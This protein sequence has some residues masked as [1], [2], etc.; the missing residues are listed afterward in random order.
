MENILIIFNDRLINTREVE[1]RVLYTQ[2]HLKRLE[3]AGLFPRRCKLGPSRVAW[4]LRA[5]IEWMQASIDQ[6]RVYFPHIDEVEIDEAD[7]F[8]GKTRASTIARISVTQIRKLEGRGEFPTRIQLG[9]R[10]VAWLER[11]VLA[12]RDAR[13]ANPSQSLTPPQPEAMLQ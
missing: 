4:S 5:V 3:T 13:S 9:P 11:E 2:V 8:I 6:R 1:N 7:R 10:R 12:W